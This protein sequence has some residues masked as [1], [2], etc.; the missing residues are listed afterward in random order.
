MEP[1]ARTRSKGRKR[2]IVALAIV[3]LLGLL[4][5][6]AASLGSSEKMSAMG[7]H[8]SMRKLW[9][10]HVTWTRLAIV[11]IGADLPDTAATV[12]R[13][14]QN[15]VDIGT[16]IKP[17][18]GEAAG[19][20]LTALLTDHIVLAANILADFKAG[21]TAGV[22][23]NV[24]LWYANANEI[25]VFLNAAN[26]KHW[27]V[28]ALHHMMQIHLDLTLAEAV[29]QLTGDYAGSVALY[30]E[31]HLEILTMADMLSAGIVAQFPNL[32]NGALPA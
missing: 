27:P 13:L 16:A 17:F 26:P 21:D 22:E 30:E 18:Y 11:S 7:F 19:D 6:S 31:V 1:S 28:D 10:D 5:L 29:A 12:N 9:E 32:F 15:Q 3:G 2:T 23:E 14:L 4:A 8:D 20:R 24:S 25:A